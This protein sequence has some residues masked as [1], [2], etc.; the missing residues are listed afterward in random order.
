MAAATSPHASFS[1]LLTLGVGEATYAVVLEEETRRGCGP[2]VKC[3]GEVAMT[4]CIDILLT[5]SKF[6]CVG[7]SMRK[8]IRTEDKP[9]VS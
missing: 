9:G 7:T 5:F 3:C 2:I 6:P 4:C 8:S 1:L